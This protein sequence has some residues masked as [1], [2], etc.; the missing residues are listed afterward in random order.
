MKKTFKK[1]VFL[2][3]YTTIQIG[4]PAKYFYEIFTLEDLQKVFLFIEKE[5]MK[6]F[7]L[8]KGSNCLFDDRGFNGLVLLNKIDFC[9]FSKNICYVGGG[10]SLSLLEKE[11]EKRK[12]SGLE[13]AKGIP[14][15]VGGAVY[16][17]AGGFNQNI[18][19]HLK[20]VIFITEQGKK[21]IIKKEKI[22]FGYRFSSL[23][24][25]KG[26]I[27]ACTFS[28]PRKLKEGKE[29]TNLF[30]EKRKISQPLSK[31]SAGC[32]FKNTK[33]KSAG[34]IIEQ[35]G[36]KDKRKGGAVISSLHANFILNEKKATAQNILSLISLIQKK[37]FEKTGIHL[38]KEICYIPFDGEDK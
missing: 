25:K 35:C 16:M 38:E 15:T 2:K 17:N 34:K 21:E 12:F 26:A 20:E 27:A 1:N 5:K 11:L 36:L 24:K 29:R 30:W 31:K 18:S 7:L 14:A 22:V 23:Q 19:D 32:I 8:G 6:Y 28:F 4:G 37:V 33:K 10:Y 3:D 9:S 13:F